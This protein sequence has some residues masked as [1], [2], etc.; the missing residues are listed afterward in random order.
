MKRAV[1]I[2]LVLAAVAAL[3]VFALVVPRQAQRG[4]LVLAASS[5]QESLEAVAGEWAAKGHA[6]PV[7]SF[8]ATPALARQVEAGARADI[9]ISADEQW[10]DELAR[11]NLIRQATRA[12]FLGNRLVL[13]EPAGRHTRL[14]LEP[15]PALASTLSRGRIAIADPQAVP[16]GRYAKAALASLGVWEE[17]S[18]QLV[19]TEN[20]RAAAA[21]VAQGEAA[22]GIVYA[23]DAQADRKLRVIATF[24]A[25]SHAPIAYPLAL[26]ETSSNR[27]AAGFRQFLLSDEAGAIFRSFGFDTDIRR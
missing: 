19:Q 5:L 1:T 17:L 21:L 10:M 2:A 9:F 12:T 13:V 8:A 24:P 27:D 23:T 14:D 6:R 26:L 22:F 11:R 7:L 20:V 15:G 4:P 18:G 25:T 3:A 16:A